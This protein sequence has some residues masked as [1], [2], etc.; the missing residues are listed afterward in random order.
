MTEAREY[1]FFDHRDEE[2]RIRVLQQMLR[3]VSRFSGD[4]SLSTRVDGRFDTGTEN[5][6]RAFQ[7]KYGLSETGRVDLAGWEKLREVY[8]VYLAENRP[9]DPIYPFFDP[10]LRIRAGE[11]SG[12]VMLLQ[13]LL[14]E[15][16]TFYDGYADLAVNGVY[17]EA[18]AEAIRQ[19]QRA[20]LL[21]AT[22]EVDR[23]TW[24][25]LAAEYNSALGERQ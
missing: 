8:G 22:G 5:A 6:W 1:I 4:L 17:D 10:A 3:T 16:Q 24:N 20:N 21:D 18:T 25:R 7:R 19:F 11:R 14:E 2:N 23:T 9:A 13:V 15:L 12:L